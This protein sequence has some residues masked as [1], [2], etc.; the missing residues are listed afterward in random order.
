MLSAMPEPISRSPRTILL[1][2]LAFLLLLG[3]GIGVAW[4]LA[5]QGILGPLRILL[6]SPQAEASSGLEA[7]QG[8]AIGALVQDHLEHYGRFAITTVTEVPTDLEL[9][10]GQSR[11]LLIL[12]EPRRQG[13]DLPLGGI[14]VLNHVRPVSKSS[15]RSSS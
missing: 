9:F 6:I 2:G 5:R 4:L 1:L 13:D 15:L 10:R 11:T 14:L 8:R 12:T 7:A 3:G